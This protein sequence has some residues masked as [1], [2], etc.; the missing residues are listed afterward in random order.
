M[1]TLINIIEFSL[2]NSIFLLGF[3]GPFICC[4]RRIYVGP[5]GPGSEFWDVAKGGGNPPLSSHAA[6]TAINDFKNNPDKWSGP[7]PPGQNPGGSFYREAE[8]CGSYF[9]GWL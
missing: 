3:L 5:P 4:K 7:V 9:N 8:F 2:A 1:N 6:Q